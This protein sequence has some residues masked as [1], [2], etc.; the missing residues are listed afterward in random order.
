MKVTVTFKSDFDSHE[1]SSAF[2]E[3]TITFIKVPATFIPVNGHFIKA[4]LDSH[5]GNTLLKVTVTFIEV[6]SH[7]LF[8]PCYPT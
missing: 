7:F 3:V 4:T 5:L 2:L 1:S 8:F 6:L